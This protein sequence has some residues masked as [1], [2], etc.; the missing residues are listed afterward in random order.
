MDLKTAKKIIAKGKEDGKMDQAIYN[1]LSPHYSDK[2][3]LALLIT[4]TAT[5]E[6]RLKYKGYNY[7]LLG[8]LSAVALL[9][10]MDSLYLVSAGEFSGF[11]VSLVG[12]LLPALFIYGIAQYSG[13]VYRFCGIMAVLGLLPAIARQ[14][15]FT[16]I[17]LNVVPLAAIAGLCFYLDRK[18]FPHFRP[19][20]M[21][22]DNNG[23]YVL[24]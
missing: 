12:W 2:K 6:D 19:G 13:P 17:L 3:N 14:N 15:D 20:K 7:L 23:N 5:K 10:I 18:M 24:G 9:R 4:G 21:K 22:K 16:G 1:D 8:L 11:L